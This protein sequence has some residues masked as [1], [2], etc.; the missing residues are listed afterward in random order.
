M[1]KKFFYL[2][3]NRRVTIC[4][5]YDMY[6]EH[7]SRGISICSFQDPNLSSEGR[8]KAEGRALQAL[9]NESTDCHDI[10]CRHEAIEVLKEEGIYP[11]LVGAF[12]GEFM[13]DLLP[14]EDAILFK[15][16]TGN[17]NN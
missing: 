3:A 5:L 12:R 10:I 15:W 14:I 13:P 6:T 9:Y 4:L 16:V 2:G 1:R 11:F 7:Y 8:A 17:E